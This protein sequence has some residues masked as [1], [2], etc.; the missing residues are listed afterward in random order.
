MATA[1]LKSPS[2]WDG[3]AGTPT[4]TFLSPSNHSNPSLLLPAAGSWQGKPPP[5]QGSSCDSG[6]RGEGKKTALFSP[7]PWKSSPAAGALVCASRC[8]GPSLPIKIYTKLCLVWNKQAVA[9]QDFTTSCL[10]L[11]SNIPKQN[12]IQLASLQIE[13]SFLFAA[14]AEQTFQYCAPAPAPAF[15]LRVMRWKDV[16]DAQGH[17]QAVNKPGSSLSLSSVV[18]LHRVSQRGAQAEG[19]GCICPAGPVA[20]GWFLRRG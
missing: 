7:A 16:K 12:K 1:A 10:W 5:L 20:A 3:G 19:D 14:I 4:G 11:A 9:A 2:Y 18:S 17:G 13:A 8:V 15:L 6:C